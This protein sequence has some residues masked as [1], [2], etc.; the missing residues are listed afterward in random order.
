MPFKKKVTA[1][2]INWFVFI[3]YAKAIQD[4]HMIS[5]VPSTVIYK[6]LPLDFGVKLVHYTGDISPW[7]IS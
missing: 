3:V 2:G 7:H 5:E 6:I 1:S 4:I